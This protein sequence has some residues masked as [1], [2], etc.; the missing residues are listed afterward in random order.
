MIRARLSQ[1]AEELA[2]RVA[3]IQPSALAQVGAVAVVSTLALLPVAWLG[4]KRLVP[5]RNV[6]FARWG[7]SHVGLA[8]LLLVGGSYL[9]SLVLPPDE[10]LM[11][12]LWISAAGMAA[13]VAGIVF[14]SVKLD[15][16]GVK[17]LGLRAGGN[18]RAIAAALLLYGA[19]MPGIF[20]LAQ[21]W[22]WIL[23]LFG[24]NPQVQEVAKRFAELPPD[25]RLVPLVLGIAVVPLFE[26]I[27]FR[28]FLQPLLVQNVREVA[29]VAITSAIFAALHGVD[30]FL[31][32]FALSCV[33]G[34]IMLRTQRLAASWMI[35]ALNNG[36]M[37]A[38]LI[39]FPELAG[40]GAP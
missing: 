4:V 20:G 11:R 27:L 2:A 24:H 35:H 39:R 18:A 25:E 33:F 28:S 14:W 16:D 21:I 29:G 37:F 5:Q 8:I 31:P 15:P 38:V 3:E 7:F 40:A 17:S 13:A 34:V 6:V 32:L 12:A 1:S 26:E 9:A 22:K 19:A 10:G 30:V 23:G 36:L